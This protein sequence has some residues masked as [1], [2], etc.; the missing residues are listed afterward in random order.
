MNYLY[1]TL[2]GA[3]DNYKD[4]FTTLTSGDT[5][6]DR[7]STITG[8]SNRWWSIVA[9]DNN[10][11]SA[12]GFVICKSSLD[13]EKFTFSMTSIVKEFYPTHLTI[14]QI[15]NIIKMNA[16]VNEII[17]ATEGFIND[18]DKLSD[19]E[20]ADI[21][22]RLLKEEMVLNT[23]REYDEKLSNETKSSKSK[24]EAKIKELEASKKEE[25]ELYKATKDKEYQALKDSL[26]EQDKLSNGR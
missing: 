15:G 23:K 18:N 25:M 5:V 21:V 19:K 12:S 11:N 10:A 7:L 9:Q 6:R 22:E 2:I 14:L 17:K 24:L 16:S 3:G 8:N 20:K 26:L 1:L 13:Y 4:N